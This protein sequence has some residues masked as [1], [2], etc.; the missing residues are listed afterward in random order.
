MDARDVCRSTVDTRHGDPAAVAGLAMSKQWARRGLWKR[1]LR[2]SDVR[3][4]PASVA[5]ARLVC[6]CQAQGAVCCYL[7]SFRSFLIFSC[8]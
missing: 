7:H 6:A 5:C 8:Q 1:R 4:A 2:N 3:R